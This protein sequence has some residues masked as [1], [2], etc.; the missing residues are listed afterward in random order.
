[1]SGDETLVLLVS[2]VVG[3]GGWALWLF[4][5]A[6]FGGLRRGRSPVRVVATTLV[7]LLV[8]IVVILRLCAA[9]DVRTSPAYMFMYSALGLAWLRL[10]SLALPLAGL[11]PRDDLIERRNAAA[12]PVWI[13][14]MTGAALCYAGGNIGNGPGWWVVVFSG[15][16]ATA[17]LAAVWIALDEGAGAA[18]S[19]V[20]DRDMA[21]GVR[22]AGLLTAAGIICGEAVTGDWISAGATIAD[23]GARAWPLVPLVLVAIA[24]ERALGPR[25]ERPR[26]PLVQA[27]AVPALLYLV[28]ATGVV[29][30]PLW[31]RM[32]A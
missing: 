13:G 14:A 32:A 15:G 7:V 18:D 27:G 6:S 4:R 17:A 23:F 5:A 19:V 24:I 12:L 28:F 31:P 3:L 29:L 8:L 30:W 1:M 2:V 10:A 25:P 26:A 22:L 21:A 11:H 16:L 9:D 20:I